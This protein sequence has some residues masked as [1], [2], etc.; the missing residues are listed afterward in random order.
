MR[1]RSLV[2]LLW[3]RVGR[4]KPVDR[5]AEYLPEPPDSLAPSLAGTLLDD[6][7]DMQDIVASIVDL[8]RR[9]AI[10]ITE[11]KEEGFFRM[12]T[13]FVYRRERRDVPLQP[14]ELE[15]LQGVFGSKDEVRLSDLKNKFYKEIPAI[16]QSM[17][18]DL[19]Q[20]NYYRQSPETVRS[21]FG[22]IGVAAIVVAVAAS[23]L[24]FVTLIDFTVAAVCPGF[25]LFVTALAL[26]L[27]ARAMPRKTDAGSE[28]AARWRAFKEY[29][30]NIDKYTDIDAQKAIWDRWLPY[31]IAF[32][33]DKSYIRKFE[34]VNAPAP[35]WYIPSPTLYGPYHRR[36]YGSGGEGG[37]PV[38]LPGGSG[39]NWSG[40]GGLGDA[41]KGLGTSLAGM[42]AG[43]GTLL[44]S[45]SSTFNSRPSSSGSSGGGWSGGGGFGG[46]GGGGGGGGFG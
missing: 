17:Y 15:L 30:Q 4:D 32:G 10:S 9:K 18:A 33:I 1:A 26:L 38:T 36:Y 11:E 22:C 25:G 31:A 42:S 40:G 21:T 41:S 6:S 16:K 5:V 14:F 34:G 37:P 23:F 8:A 43:L 45:A 24:L 27:A 13:D 39:G 46:G 20:R 19:I 35:G 28:T 29:L 7:A 44:S 2:Y 12:G 3:Y